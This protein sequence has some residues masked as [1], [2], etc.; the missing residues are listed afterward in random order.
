MEEK[1]FQAVDSTLQINVRFALEENLN[2]GMSIEEIH[3]LVGSSTQFML[4]GYSKRT[5]VKNQGNVTGDCF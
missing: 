1:L 4:S 5:G 2:I 3:K